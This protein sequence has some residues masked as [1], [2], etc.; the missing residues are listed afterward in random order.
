MNLTKSF[1]LSLV[2]LACLLPGCI[3]YSP[4][5]MGIPNQMAAALT[6]EDVVIVMRRAGFSDEQIL[7]FGPDLR[8][9]MAS[10]GAVQIRVG[11]KVDAMFAVSEEHLVV[12]TRS[13]GTFSYPLPKASVTVPMESTRPAI[14]Q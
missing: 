1:L 11:D 8:N 2:S 13:N 9:L 4:Q 7:K 3:S 14:R 10:A 5:V 6:A 12:S